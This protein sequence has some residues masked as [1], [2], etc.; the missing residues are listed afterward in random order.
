M[1]K[2]V[3]SENFVREENPS[4]GKIVTIETIRDPND[5]HYSKYFSPEFNVKGYRSSIEFSPPITLEGDKNNKLFLKTTWY[6]YERP[7]WDIWL[8]SE[9]GFVVGNIIKSFSKL[10]EAFENYS[11]ERLVKWQKEAFSMHRNVLLKLED[12]F[13]QDKEVGCDFLSNISPSKLF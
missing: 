5:F 1:G 8:N 12:L 6:D 10:N 3:G 11:K 9:R 13:Y 2:V 4:T 7:Y